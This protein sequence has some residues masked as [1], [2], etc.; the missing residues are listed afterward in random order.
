MKEP[1]VIPPVPAKKSLKFSGTCGTMDVPK[2][3]IVSIKVAQ[4]SCWKELCCMLLIP[5]G[6]GG[7]AASQSTEKEMPKRFLS[8]VSVFIEFVE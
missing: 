6:V 7:M 3:E 4:P 8:W 5:T 2:M 1:L